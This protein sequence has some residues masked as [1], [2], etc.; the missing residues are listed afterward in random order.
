MVRPMVKHIVHLVGVLAGLA[1]LASACSSTSNSNA[2][3]PM[4][5][6][7]LTRAPSGDSAC[8][9]QNECFVTSGQPDHT[10]CPNT[11]SCTCANGQCFERDCTSAFCTDPPVYH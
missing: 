1:C 3:T 4:C 9:G 8:A 5:V 6:Q 2:E 7:G 11:C 10:G